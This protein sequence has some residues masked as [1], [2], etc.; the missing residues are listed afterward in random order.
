MPEETEQ[1]V[2]KKLPFEEAYQM[3]EDGRDHRFNVS[4]RHSKVK[5][6]FAWK[7]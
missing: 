1:L 4:S 2:I 3:V 7:D 6:A 5:Y